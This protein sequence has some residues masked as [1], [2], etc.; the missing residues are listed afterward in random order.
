MFLIQVGWLLL[1]ALGVNG[2]KVQSEKQAIAEDQALFDK[3]ER[4]GV[5]VAPKVKRYTLKEIKG[6]N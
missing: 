2:A 6:G 3:L 4:G 1:V 5:V